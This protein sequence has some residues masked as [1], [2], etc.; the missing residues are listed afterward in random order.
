MVCKEKGVVDKC[1]EYL[2]STAM[3]EIRNLEEN[4]DC[5]SIQELQYVRQ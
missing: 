2:Q 1:Q 3:N 4:I 5:S